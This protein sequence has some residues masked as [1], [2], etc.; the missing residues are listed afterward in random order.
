MEFVLL[1]IACVFISTS[2]LYGPKS[3]VVIVTEKNF[4][5]E[6][7][8]SNA[9]VIVEFFAPWCGHCKSLTPEY[10]KA[11]KVLKGVVKLVAI[12][13]TVSES[14]AQQFQ[15]KGFPTLK[16]F[17]ADKKNP[18]EYAGQRT[19]DGLISEGMKATNQMIKSR[20]A[21]KTSSNNEKEKTTTKKKEKNSDAPKKEKKEKK[22]KGSKS[23]VVE[24]NDLN[25]N[26]LVLESTDHWLVEFFAPW[27]GHCKKLGFFFF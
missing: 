8:K 3:D 13:A 14:L 9:V 2:A 18:T 16:V 15:I 7:L 6:V 27:C 1:V 10:E 21:G 22:A 17:G 24:L 12:D 19:S 26:E 4:Q 5:Q 11:A 25:F 20:K 23:A